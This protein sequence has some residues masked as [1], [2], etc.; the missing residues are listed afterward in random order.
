VN[1]SRDTAS[2]ATA[3]VRSVPAP[4]GEA[5]QFPRGRMTA[6]VRRGLTALG[7]G[8]LAHVN[9]R[10]LAAVTRWLAS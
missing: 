7:F 4:T 9:R 5:P 6:A 3:L 1:L 10:D 2:L 8:S